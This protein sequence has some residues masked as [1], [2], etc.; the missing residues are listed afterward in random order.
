MKII[1]LGT[2][3]STGVPQIACKCKTC[4]SLNPKDKRLRASVL[5]KVDNNQILIDCGP[6]FRSQ[7][8]NNDVQFLSAVLITHEHYDHISGLDDLRPFGEI[9][10]FAEKRVCSV[11][12][13]NMPYCFSE[14]L[15][16]GVPSLRINEITD[17]SFEINSIKIQPIRVLHAKL[18]IFGYRIGKMAY[19][20][21]VKTIEDYSY[22]LLG[23]LEVLILN[24]LRMNEH[25]GHI[26]LNE[27]I[28]IAK[29]I[30]AKKTFFIHFSHD[31]G[32]H[33]DV[34]KL[35]A[36]NMFLSYDNLEITI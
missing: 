25:I 17:T 8:L 33:E 13:L 23:G 15:Y 28:A 34:Q 29:K 21:D 3:T 24:A 32:N 26:T 11:I 27:A 14:N 6:D 18:P 31:I 12:K 7:M 30:N 10:I 35:L 36:N 16:P 4:T 1:F 2:G 20:T 22:E 19:L 9:N 5:I